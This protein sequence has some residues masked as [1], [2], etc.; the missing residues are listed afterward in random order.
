MVS[1]RD[2]LNRARWRDDGLEA[3]VV[4]VLH[5]GAP[6]DLRE[7]HGRFIS[8]IRGGGIDVAPASECVD[9]SFVPY[10]RF[11]AIL[12]PDGGVLWSKERGEPAAVVEV[13]PA[14]T[15]A[16]T[17]I[18]R[19]FD[20]VVHEG[21]G[22]LVIDGSVGEGG[23]QMLRTSLTL[24]LATGTPF[25]LENI[26][27]GRTRP[28]LLRQHLTAVNA[29]A[30]LSGAVVEGAVLGSSRLVF[31]PGPVRGGDHVLDIGSAGSV[32]LVLQAIALPLLG[33]ERASRITI[34][35]G[36]HAL[37]A[38]AFP[39]LAQAWLPLVRRA[40]AKIGLGLD[41][42]GFHPAGGGAVTLTTEPS[43]TLA[44]LH[45]REGGL[46]SELVLRA[47]VAGLPEA[48]GERELAAAAA[49]LTDERLDIGTTTV[50]APGKGNAMWLV[51]RDETT[52][53]A[54][55]F[56]GIGEVG[57]AAEKI[58]ADVANAFLAWRASGAAVEGHLA[59]QLMLPIVL[60]GEG[61][62]TCSELTLHAW[63]NIAVIE[64]FTGKRLRAFDLG[65]GRFRVE[66]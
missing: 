8:A 50:D 52:G 41:R 29:A 58:G 55:V 24:S 22:E 21:S 16:R 18:T 10:H 35:G 39:F 1:Q 11:L 36:T 46:A 45:V 43:G 9:A 20:V 63:T 7:I 59:D 51:A 53:V 34:R 37:W 33:C 61:S 14:P 5:R 64:A 44:P 19:A 40:G 26:R 57:V 31:R 56:T 4:H 48:I 49:L 12:G 66:L 6:G 65:D 62:F 27:A 42:V 25:V 2:I 28:G 47:I 32:G 13:A 30:L 17:E 23:G 54:N 60:A 3:L 15:P 38:P